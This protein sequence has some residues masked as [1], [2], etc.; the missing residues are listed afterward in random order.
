MPLTLKVCRGHVGIGSSVWFPCVCLFVCP[1][2]RP[3]YKQSAIF[4]VSV[5]IQF[6]NLDCKFI[7]GLLTLRWHHMPLGTGQG[8][9]VGIKEF[10]RNLTFNCC[11]WS[12][13]VSQTRAKPLA[14][15]LSRY[16]VKID[17]LSL[18]D[19]VLLNKV[20]ETKVLIILYS[21]WIQHGE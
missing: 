5:V 15:S 14:P 18:F 4:N 9:N 3:A 10:N 17:L 1:L 11:H 8:Q 12:I 21:K 2:F 6:S 19:N 20:V 16:P 7:K 13:R